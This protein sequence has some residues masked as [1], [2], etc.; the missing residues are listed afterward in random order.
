[1][2]DPVK[3]EVKLAYD[4]F[5]TRRDDWSEEYTKAYPTYDDAVESARFFLSN[6]PTG[7]VRGIIREVYVAKS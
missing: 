7:Y 4:L 6:F 2:Q 1:M 5:L 3:L